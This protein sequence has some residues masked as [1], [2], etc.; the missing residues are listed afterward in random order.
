MFNDPKDGGFP[1][2]PDGQYLMKC[3]RIEDAE[4]GQYG[5]RVKWVFLLWNAQTRQPVVWDNDGSP[6]EWWRLTSTKTGQKST[7]RKWM[8]A[9]LNREITAEDTG[10]GLAQEVIG[11]Y[12]LAM[13]STNED[14]YPDIVS[15]KPY[16][17]QGAAAPAQAP[18]PAPEPVAAAA[19]AADPFAGVGDDEDTPF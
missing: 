15:I 16:V 19:P 10:A 8:Q 14:G 18:A 11:K 3:E 17:K 6:Y 4:P 7:A 12:A 1:E 5:P 13:I 2:I 9:F